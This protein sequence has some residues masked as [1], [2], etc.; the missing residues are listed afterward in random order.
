MFSARDSGGTA[1]GDRRLGVGKEGLGRA[2]WMQGGLE[3]EVL[4]AGGD[5]GRSMI[6]AACAGFHASVKNRGMPTGDDGRA[7]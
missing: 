4:T 1:Q 7:S 2:R 3:L 6:A 5:L